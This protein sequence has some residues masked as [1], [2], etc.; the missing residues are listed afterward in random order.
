M[1]ASRPMSEPEGW[2]DDAG[3]DRLIGDWHIYQRSGGHRTSTDDLITAWYAIHRSPSPPARYL[4]LGCG[5][6]S[7]LLMVSHKLRPRIALGVE[8]QAPSVAMARRAIA[9]L[10]EHEPRIEVHHADFRELD[11]CGERYDLITASPPYFPIDAGVLPEDPQRRACRFEERGGV[12][13]YVETAA[14]ALSEGARFYVVFQT[15]WAARVTSAAAE[16]ELHLTGRAD[17]LMRA[18]RPGPF[19]TVF[20]LSPEPAE[21]VH[22]SRCS[23]RDADGRISPEYRRIRQELGVSSRGDS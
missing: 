1:R 15:R 14:R 17:F 5:V 13:A 19:L 20:E 16:H 12:E 10:P 9:E 7:V 21:V 6:G 3:R 11:F 4:D 22:R 8:A 23:V 18:D 2:P